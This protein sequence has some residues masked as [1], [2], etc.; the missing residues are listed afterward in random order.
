METNLL[1]MVARQG[2]LEELSMVCNS[3]N[4]VSIKSKSRNR[5]SQGDEG[6]VSLSGQLEVNETLIGARVNEGAN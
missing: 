1:D 2:H 5:V 4:L 3:A 6:N